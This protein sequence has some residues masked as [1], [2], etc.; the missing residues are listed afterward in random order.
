MSLPN[1]TVTLAGSGIV[2]NN[3][4]TATV[5]D[6]YRS[7]IIQAENY[8]QAHFTNSVVL[9]VTF[10]VTPITDGAVAENAFFVYP[11]SYSDLVAALTSHA[12]TADDRLAVAGLPLTDPSGFQGFR[13]TSGEGQALGLLSPSGQDDV[14]VTISSTEPWTFG[15]D[16]VGAIEHE[17]TE[18][19]FGRAQA[20]GLAAT[21][22]APFD[23]FRFNFMGQRDYTGG[24]DGLATVFGVD[25][26]HLSSLIFH[27][28]IS[29]TGVNDGGDLGDWELT[30]ED[31]F[32]GGG[33]GIPSSIS[34]VDLQVL[35]VLGWTPSGAA[36]GSGPDD[37]AD[38]FTDTTRPFGQLT[39]GTPFHGTLQ[40]IGDH[41]WF[42]VTLVG[43]VDYVINLT[44]QDGSGGTL[45]DP[46][47]TL[48][49]AAG[50]TITSDDDTPFGVFDSQLIVH[51]ATTATYYLE[52]NSYLDLTTGSFTISVQP[53]ATAST[54][55][56]DVLVGTLAGGT[57]MA[58]D[59]NDTIDGGVGD[60]WVV[61]GKGDDSQM[62]GFG[63]DIVW[64]NLGNDTL[65]GGS[66]NDQIRGGQGDDSISGGSGNDYVSGDRG[67][68]TESGGSGADMFHTFSGA[69]IDRVLD[70]AYSQGDRVML[71]PGTTFT[72]SQ[73]GADTV[74]DMGNGDQMILVGVTLSTLPSDWIF[75]SP[76]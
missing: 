74:V 52:A 51:P 75:V 35:D 60:D 19:G 59:G 5:T 11:V 63:D 18:G 56:D 42:K 9:N 47:L 28:A 40:A 27:N 76:V 73:V 16:L 29:A 48:H 30:Y 26:Q 20:L 69:G 15:S 67:N 17:L 45:D 71:D 1:E 24:S 55:G 65:S 50:A 62:G 36:A 38:S 2:F 10:D 54:P 22:F 72:A 7:A 43:G 21:H 3:T 25:G 23:L 6:P 68:D 12:T 39:P 13:I 66:G 37:F 41:D 8:L 34:A 44:G 49:D 61:G 14:D 58:G 53:G 31:A 46:V 4:Y 33:G 32:G 57:I 70:F 64:G